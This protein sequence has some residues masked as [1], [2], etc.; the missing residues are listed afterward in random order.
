[1]TDYAAFTDDSGIYSLKVHLLSVR[2]DHVI[3]N[4]T[5]KAAEVAIVREQ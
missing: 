1:M 4:H 5:R 2:A 3:I